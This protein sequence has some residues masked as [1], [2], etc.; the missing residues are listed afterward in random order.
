MERLRKQDEEFC[1][2]LRIAVEM[3]DEFCSTTVITAPCRAARLEL[4]AYRLITRLVAQFSTATAQVHPMLLWAHFCPPA[5]C[6][7]SYEVFGMRR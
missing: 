3:G 5:E 4:Y 2:R 6:G 7:G 1:R